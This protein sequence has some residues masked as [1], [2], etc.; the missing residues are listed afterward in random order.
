MYLILYKCFINVLIKKSKIYNESS[1]NFQRA[2]SN[3]T[4]ILLWINCISRQKK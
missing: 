2:H 1:K 4:L 3:Y